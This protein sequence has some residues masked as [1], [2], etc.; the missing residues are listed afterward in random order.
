[1]AIQIKLQTCFALSG[2][3][4]EHIHLPESVETIADLLDHMSTQLE[5]PL[6]DPATGDTDIDIEIS[7]N[8]K[9]IWFYP[10][11][12]ETSLKEGDIV[13]IYLLPLGGG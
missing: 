13:E 10:K 5:F 4:S 6:R 12:L 3:E 7:L 1:L 2:S 11:G 9:E 8:A